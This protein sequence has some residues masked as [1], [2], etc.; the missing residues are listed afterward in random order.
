MVV[1]ETINFSE[2]KARKDEL[3]DIADEV[4]L[5]FEQQ[6]SA[7]K[8]VKNNMFDVNDEI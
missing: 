7:S 6:Y 3:G 4:Y 1:F 5:K 8:K 2:G